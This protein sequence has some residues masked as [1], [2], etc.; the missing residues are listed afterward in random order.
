MKNIFCLV[1]VLGVLLLHTGCESRPP[2]T[3]TPKPGG[4]DENTVEPSF[5]SPTAFVIDHSRATLY[6][7]WDYKGSAAI[8]AAGFAIKASGEADFSGREADSFA[9]PMMLSLAGLSAE[10]EYEFYAY[11][12]I[13]DATYKS[14]S[15]YFTTPKE[16]EEPP[17]IGEPTFSTPVASNVTHSSAT[18]SGTYASP[19]GAVVEEAGFLWKRTADAS[20]TRLETASYASPLTA[21]LTGLAEQ[22][23]YEFRS[24]V[25][26][27]NKQYDS[28]AAIFTTTKGSSDTPAGV[29]RT[30]WLELPKEVAK[31]GDYYYAYHMRDDA[32][33][34]R[35]Y[36]LCYSAE[37]R[38]AVWAA[39][40]MHDCYI[41]SGRNE[42][43][44]YDP[45]IPQNVQPDLSSSYK[46]VSGYSRGHMIANSD[47]TVTP[48]TSAQTFYYTNMAPQI[49]NEFNGSAWGKLENRVQG[50]MNDLY[51]CSDS[52]YVVSGSYW[53]NTSR[54][55]TDADGNRVVIPTHFYKV[56]IRSRNGNTRKSLREL[57]ASEI[58]C[59]GFWM[60]HKSYGTKGDVDR[61]QLV[62]VAEIERRTGLTFFSNI[63]NA[64]K[65]TF[66]HSDWGF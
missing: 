66:V 43:W 53:E 37:Y 47:R 11:A 44:R 26:I 61:S 9:S 40:V 23:S 41:G 1:I 58:K 24:Y 39:M 5:R 10:T 7:E 27:D 8:V 35:N 29:Y 31:Q 12:T 16:G 4:G 22:T 64:P 49:G 18:I 21:A 51:N 62:S 45:K 3:F 6:C 15:S 33:S 55:C 14:S 46:S 54:T 63:P 30:G 59:V 57:S 34:I 13:G 17:V 2:E 48:S 56:M 28:A 19:E 20:F 42:R 25:V 38:S 32:P 52:L 60:E 50:E 36:S 65:Q